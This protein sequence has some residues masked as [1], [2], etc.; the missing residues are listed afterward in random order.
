[1]ARITRKVDKR[2]IEEK[3]EIIEK[4]N[5][6]FN[7]HTEKGFL[8]TEL[9]SDKAKINELREMRRSLRKEYLEVTREAIPNRL[10]IPINDDSK[11]SIAEMSVIDLLNAGHFIVG[12]DDSDAG[13]EPVNK[14]FTLKLRVKNL[15]GNWNAPTV[16]NVNGGIMGWSTSLDRTPTLSNMNGKGTIGGTLELKWS[17]NVP[18]DGVYIFQPNLQLILEG[19]CFADGY[20]F[21]SSGNDAEAE[22]SL[23]TMV[24]LDNEIIHEDSSV[25]KEV[26]SKRNAAQKSFSKYLLLLSQVIGIEARKGQELVVRVRVH[27]HTWTRESADAEVGIK[28]FGAIANV[29]SDTDIPVNG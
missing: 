20:W 9:G 16:Q 18:E 14:D 28:M 19:Y 11:H 22:V 25:I 15:S 8:T 23:I 21:G 29:P 17:G 3:L 5:L 12:S 24:H 6:M 27:G 4:Y 26:V 13:C 1:M 2:S 7:G 10:L